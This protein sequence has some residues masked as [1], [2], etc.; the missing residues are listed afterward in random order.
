MLEVQKQKQNPLTQE[1]LKAASKQL[2]L[3][4]G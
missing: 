4:S 2:S 3:A 1:P